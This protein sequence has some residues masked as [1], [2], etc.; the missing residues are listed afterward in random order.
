[1]GA[2]QQSFLPPA[3]VRKRTGLE[4]KKFA[5]QKS[6]RQRSTVQ[7]QQWH[8]GTRAGIV[9]GLRK[10]A[11]AGAAFA[12]QQNRGVLRLGR[13][14]CNFEHAARGF[15]LGHDFAEVITSARLFDVVA[16]ANTQ[17]EHLACTV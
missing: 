12:L 1:M 13:F 3:R 6:I 11:F 5:F 15:V 2:F 16:D 10:H 8:G 7:F 17:R 9:N 14:A 4:A